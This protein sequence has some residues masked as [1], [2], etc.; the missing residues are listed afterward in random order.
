[1]KRTMVRWREVFIG[2]ILIF[3]SPLSI[4]ASGDGDLRTAHAVMEETTSRVMEVLAE[5]ETY[6]DEDP[7][8][9][10]Q[11]IHGVLDELVDFD[12]FARAVMGRYA[13]RQRY[14]A[15]NADQKMKFKEQV[16]RFSSVIRIG[17]VRTYGKGLLAFNGSE[18]KIMPP[19]ADFD[20]ND[21]S[22]TVV[23]HIYSEAKDPY[24]IRYSMHKSR[25][26]AW[27]MRNMIVE[28]INLGQIYRNQFEAAMRDHKGNIDRVIDSWAIDEGDSDAEAKLQAGASS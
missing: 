16:S 6:H 21:S 3:L 13:S 22:I 24:I 10:Y 23:Q 1:M 20:L 7:D 2:M 28:S 17:L 5:A 18:V 11:Q 19:D 8:R 4:A 14:E 9:Y 15:M 27:R 26:E 25:S 12:F